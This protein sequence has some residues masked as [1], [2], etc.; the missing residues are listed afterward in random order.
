MIAAETPGIPARARRRDSQ[1]SSVR[2]IDGVAV[3]IPSRGPV[4]GDGW[5]GGPVVPGPAL[6]VDVGEGP[7]A[8]DVA[9]LFEGTGRELVVADAPGAT[10]ELPLGATATA[11]RPG[12]ARSGEEPSQPARATTLKPTTRSGRRRAGLM[13]EGRA[14][15]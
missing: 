4:G 6:T 1:A 5:P 15:W 8:V 9:A 13:R 10:E 11:D 12:A 7:G 3:G 14:T 2:R